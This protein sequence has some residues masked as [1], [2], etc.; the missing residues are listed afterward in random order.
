MHFNLNE[1]GCSDPFLYILI[2]TGHQ[3]VLKSFLCV[4]LCKTVRERQREAD[5]LL[6]PS[7]FPLRSPM[8]LWKVESVFLSQRGGVLLCIICVCAYSMCS[9]CVYSV[10]Q[11]DQPFSF[12]LCLS[13]FNL[14][15]HLQTSRQGPSLPAAS[16]P[17]ALHHGQPHA[18]Q[19]APD[20]GPHAS[21][22]DSAH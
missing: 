16:I 11:E 3:M 13:L 1:T 6:N 7:A 4:H 8:M 10:Y 5:Y 21:A 2:N 17:A 22:A 18:R 15:L 9:L 19:L 12:Q 20:P 14:F